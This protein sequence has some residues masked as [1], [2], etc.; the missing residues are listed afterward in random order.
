MLL[1]L[2]QRVAPSD[3]ARKLELI[4]HYKALKQA[5]CAQEVE[6]WL[7]QW[8]EVYEK[9]KQLNL[10]DVDEDRS[11]HD[12]LHA[13]A[14]IS[15][16]FAGYWSND[17]QAKQQRAKA[18][19]GAF[20]ASFLG[21]PIN[22]DSKS[23]NSTDDKTKR[24]SDCLCGAMHRFKD[25]PYLNG[26]VPPK[27]WTADLNVQKQIDEKIENS[28][29]LRASGSGFLE[30]MRKQQSKRDS[31][32]SADSTLVKPVINTDTSST[33]PSVFTISA[34]MASANSDYYLRDSFI[35]DSGADTHVCN[36]RTHFQDLVPA[37]DDEYLYAGNSVI[38]IDGFGSVSITVQDPHGPRQ[39]IL[40]SVAL[41]P[42]FHTSVVSLDRLTKKFIGTLNTADS[43][44]I[45]THFALS[46]VV[47][48]NGSL[49]TMHRSLAFF[50]RGRNS[51]KLLTP[52]PIYGTMAL[53]ILVLTH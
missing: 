7:Q 10:P 37:A 27:G 46:N 30:R 15:P 13:V 23:N 18:S 24:H 52:L 31:S 12:F 17:V 32:T 5:P 9:C 11:L 41:V 25:C 44:T 26:S 50:W 8:E 6:V 43:R 51:P 1:A 22:G 53:A 36:D 16:D 3:R 21:K 38:P 14:T 49:S 48:A 45:T 35:L 4:N 28:A 33:K 20:S 40:Q 34:H 29:K 19:H 39:I 2:K 42:S 47:I